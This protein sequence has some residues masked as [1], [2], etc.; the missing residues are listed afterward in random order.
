MRAATCAGVGGCRCPSPRPSPVRTGRGRAR[1]SHDHRLL[2]VQ[3][4][5]GLQLG[6]LLFLVAAGLTLVFG[7]MDFINLAHG[8]QYMLGAYLAVTFYR[9]TGSFLPASCW[10]CR[11]RCCSACSL[12]LLVFRHLYERDHLDQVLATFGAHPAPEPGGE[13]RL[14]RRA[15]QYGAFPTSCRARCPLMDGML[16]PIY[17]FAIIGAGLAVAAGLSVLVEQDPHRHAA[18]GRRLECADGLGARRRYPASSS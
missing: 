9:L 18:A 12:E 17:R 4:L 15:A 7:V 2:I 10:P 14:G 6:I 16:Y 1:D 5:N 13:D 11:P 3:L 8:V